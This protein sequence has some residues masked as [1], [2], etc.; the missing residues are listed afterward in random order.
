MLIDNH[1]AVVS[2]SPAI[3]MHRG[4]FVGL[5]GYADFYAADMVKLREEGELSLKI[6]IEA[7]ERRGIPA[8]RTA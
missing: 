2:F 8:T 5:S 1:E 3:G 4:E 7:C 6:F